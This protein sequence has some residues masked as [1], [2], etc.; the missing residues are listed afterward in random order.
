[1]R[2]LIL[3]A[4]ILVGGWVVTSA[5]DTRAASPGTTVSPILSCPNLDGSSDN[6]VVIADILAVVQAYFQ[7]WPSSNYVLMYDLNNPY[8][9]TTS[10]GGQLRVDD[11]LA[12]LSSYFETCPLADTQVAQA[13]RAILTDPESTGLIMCDE[14]VLASRGYLRSSQDV[15][16]QGIHYM[17]FAYWDSAFDVAQP[18]GLVCQNGRLAAELYYIDGDAAGWGG[19]SPSGG[20][21]HGVDIDPFCSPAPCSWDGSEG[22]HAHSHICLAHVGTSQAFAGF[23]ADDAGCAAISGGVGSY[24][25]D[26]DM[27]WMGHLWNFLPNE[28]LLPD[29]AGTLNGRYADCRP[30]FKSDTCPM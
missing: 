13:T 7:D 11:I 30:P 26:D 1:L 6:R 27:G 29:V 8:N 10:T 21:V 22:W 15:P 20:A 17:N 24:Y 5:H 28:N 2:A 4:L 9:P 25:F 18:E 12:V 19:Y 3:A 23:A 16:G 14:Q